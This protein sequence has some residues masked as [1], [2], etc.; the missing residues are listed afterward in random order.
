MAISKSRENLAV[1]NPLI[2]MPSRNDRELQENQQDGFYKNHIKLCAAIP[3]VT[4][5]FLV[6]YAINTGVYNYTYKNTKTKTKNKYLQYHQNCNQKIIVFI[7]NSKRKKNARPNSVIPL[8]SGNNL[9]IL[10]LVQINQT[11]W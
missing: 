4:Q 3:Q 7:L 1:L 5:E 11:K 9:C 2:L 10:L 6:T 8:L